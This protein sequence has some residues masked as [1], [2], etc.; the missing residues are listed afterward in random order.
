[1]AFGLVSRPKGKRGAA[2]MRFPPGLLV[3]PPKIEA[4]AESRSTEYEAVPRCHDL[5]ID[6][7]ENAW[8][9]MARFAGMF[10]CSPCASTKLFCSER[11]T[12]RSPRALLG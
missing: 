2:S 8:Q 1:M 12:E 10:A 5:A 7:F 4:D 11:I 3:V 6:S 9:S